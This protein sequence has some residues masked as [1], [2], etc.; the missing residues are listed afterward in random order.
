MDYLILVIAFSTV[1][2]LIRALNSAVLSRRN[3]PAAPL[4]PGPPRL[5]VLGNLVQLRGGSPYQTLSAFAKTYGPVMSLKLGTVTTVVFST[6]DAAKEVLSKHDA[7]FADRATRHVIKA[8]DHHKASV[9]WSP[10]SANWRNLRKILMVQMF[11]THRLNA[12]QHL[13]LQKVQQLREH[14]R[15]RSRSGGAVDVGGA[16]FTTLLNMISIT[17]FSVDLAGYCSKESQ[18]FER[19]VLGVMDEGARPNMADLF[20]ALQWIDPNG[21]RKRMTLLCEK[22]MGYFEKFINER[23]QAASSSLRNNDVLDA[24]LNPSL[25]KDYQLSL[26]D[27]KHLFLVSENPTPKW[28]IIMVMLRG[29]VTLMTNFKSLIS[30]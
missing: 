5:P 1:W 23:S 9:I 10:A 3:S 28:L 13:R 8:L 11:V 19:L 20:P 25:G 27:L 15:Q 18:E 7:V 14:L 6:A 26:N 29:I 21:G 30:L 16:V 2:I 24:L 22:L 4:P 12:S 17:M